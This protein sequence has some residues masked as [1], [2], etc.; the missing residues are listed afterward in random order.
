MKD[1][2]H[3]DSISDVQWCDSHHILL[4]MN[5]HLS[6]GSIIPYAYRVDGSEDNDGFICMH[7]K[8]KYL[9]GEISNV[10]ECPEWRIKLEV[11]SVAIDVRDKRNQLLSETDYL[12]NNDYPISEEA[13]ELVRAYRQALRD[14]PQQEGFPETVVWPE[15]PACIS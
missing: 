11:D 8:N 15:K 4:G 7:V 5:I 3:V 6:D 12:T 2:I 14:V 1:D 9:S 13:R 10:S